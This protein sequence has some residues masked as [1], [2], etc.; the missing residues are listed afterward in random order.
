MASYIGRSRGFG[1]RFNLPGPS[2]FAELCLGPASDGY[3]RSFV[4]VSL[5][6][7]DVMA[8]GTNDIVIDDPVFQYVVSQAYSAFKI[9]PIVPVHLNDIFGK[10]LDIM[11]SS[12]GLPWIRAGYKT[13]R[14]VASDSA[15]SNSIRWFWH[16][17]KEGEDVRPPDC[18][19]FLRSHLV[20]S[21]NVKVRAVWGYPAT[22]TFME[23]CFA[24]P[25]IE[26]YK[27]GE[28]PIA[29]GYDMATGGARRLWRELAPYSNFLCLDFKSFD[30]TVSRQLIKIAFDILL[31]NIDFSRYQDRGT[32]DVRRLLRAWF[33]IRRYFLDTTIRL[34]TGKRFKKKAGV[35]SGSFFTQLVDSIVN[36]IIIMYGYVKA[37]GT[38]PDFLKVFGDDS[39]LASKTPLRLPLLSGV[40]GTTGMM[41]NDKKYV[42]TRSRDEVEFLGFNIAGGFPRR[43]YLKW[44]ALLYHP[45]YPDDSFDE[46]ASRAVG[47]AYANAGMCSRFHL[48]CRN[49]VQAIPFDLSL[50]K[51]MRR[52]LNNVGVHTLSIHIPDIAEF[53]NRLS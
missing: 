7:K 19:A 23:A 31:Q 18:A 47:L 36:W 11:S 22:I 4:N 15:A 51:S 32:P 5:I 9:S 10:E 35:A 46:F 6:T 30:K 52:F 40:I 24:L 37:H 41:I 14:D 44:R 53:L 2:P 33:Y 50:S 1:Q 20:E 17:I 38:K 45:E 49:I 8:F 48:E 16:R 26:R 3:E 25:L 34:C 13:K 42:S 12:P 27:L 39:V 21:G 43:D 28:T 29:Y